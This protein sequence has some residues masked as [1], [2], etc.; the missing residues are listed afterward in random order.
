MQ[1]IPSL[2]LPGILPH[3]RAIKSWGQNIHDYEAEFWEFQYEIYRYQKN[4]SDEK[5][6]NRYKEMCRNFRVL[7]GRERHVIPINTF[8][9]SW[10]WYRKEHQ[11]RYELFQRGIPLP[12][13]IPEP[14]R[15]IKKPFCPKGPNSCDILFRYGHFKYMQGFVEKG[16]IRISPASAYRDGFELDPRTDDELNKHRWE[17]GDHIRIRTQTGKEQPIIGDL[18]RTVSAPNNYYTLCVST[19]F[20]PTMF[21]LFGYDSC[22]VIKN[23]KEFAAR[24]ERVTRSILPGW[25]FLDCPI[26]YFD[27]H[28]PNRT[29]L[30]TATM[31]KDFSYAYQMEYRFLW[32]PLDKT[33]AKDHIE[34][35]LGP[36][37]DICELYVLNED[38]GRTNA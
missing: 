6:V 4:L 11:T 15:S 2:K 12:S 20:E 29:Q 38:S 34:V 37:R 24:L 22:V 27:P 26:E 18:K 14:R 7:T 30:F 8:L 23:P 21:E 25:Y 10:Y 9:S 19:D 3:E 5:V 17:L 31:C 13:P 33:S 32:D 1:K 36:L 28:E 16:K 35:N